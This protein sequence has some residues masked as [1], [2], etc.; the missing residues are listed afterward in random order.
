MYTLCLSRAS[1]NA[2][3]SPFEGPLLRMWRLCVG[4]VCRHAWSVTSFRP[5]LDQ[6]PYLYTLTL[7]CPDEKWPTIGPIYDACQKSFRLTPTTKVLH[8]LLQT[9]VPQCS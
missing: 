1:V 4:F 6:S 8:N 5:G 3:L 2:L 9:S 7:S